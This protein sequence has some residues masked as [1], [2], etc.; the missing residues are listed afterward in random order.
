MRRVKGGVLLRAMEGTARSDPR[1]LI[2]R[3]QGCFFANDPLQNL[4]CTNYSS[5]YQLQISTMDA[6][7]CRKLRIRTTLGRSI[8]TALGVRD[9]RSKHSPAAVVLRYRALEPFGPRARYLIKLTSHPGSND[10]IFKHRSK[11][12]WS[13]SLGRTTE[14]AACHEPLHHLSPMCLYKYPSGL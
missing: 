2:G 12:Q 10:Q 9:V 13:D 14:R 4:L 1:L 3:E 6:S 5:T 11:N 8:G 7:F